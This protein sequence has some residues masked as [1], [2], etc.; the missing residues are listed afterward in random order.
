MAGGGRGRILPILQG[1]TVIFPLE[2]FLEKTYTYSYKILVGEPLVQLVGAP[3]A[4]IQQ[5]DSGPH[6]G[7][8]REQV[9][10]AGKVREAFFILF[11]ARSIPGTPELDKKLPMKT[12]YWLL[13][14]KKKGKKKKVGAEGCRATWIGHACVLAEVD[15][16]TVLT[17]PVFSKRSSFVQWAGPKR[18]R[19]P[20][21]QIPQLQPLFFIIFFLQH[22]MLN[23]C[24]PK[25]TP[26]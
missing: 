8:G 18:Y 5:H 7:Q 4:G 15:G 19:P 21:R 9:K 23:N 11:F 12:P 10:L 17:D 26:S 14:G 3:Q 2:S 24:P 16:C 1:K 13:K 20:G 25:S 6:Q 22:V